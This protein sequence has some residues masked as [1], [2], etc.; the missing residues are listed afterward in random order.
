MSIRVRRAQPISDS[1]DVKGTRVGDVL[2]HIASKAGCDLFVFSQG[3]LLCPVAQLTEA[4]KA[5]AKKGLGGGWKL[6]MVFS[7]MSADGMTRLS[8]L[9]R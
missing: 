3:L 2:Q 4:E 6:N 8:G 1:F 9:L 7:T 5:D